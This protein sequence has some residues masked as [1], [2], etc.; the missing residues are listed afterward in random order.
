MAFCRAY[1][2]A[3]HNNTIKKNLTEGSLYSFEYEINTSINNPTIRITR[4]ENQTL[5]FFWDEN[6]IVIEEAN[7]KRKL[8]YFVEYADSRNAAKGIWLLK[9][10]LDVLTS[11]QTEI[12]ASRANVARSASSYNLY[13]NDDFYN[14]LAYPR[15]GCKEFSF[16]FSETYSYLLN[17]C[18]TL[19]TIEAKKEDAKNGEDV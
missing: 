12:L 3:G 8:T 6:I 1:K 5:G 15:I 19:S 11:Y 14:A 18:N 17:V 9:L 16:G 10:R 2:Y 4:P 13:L 7:G